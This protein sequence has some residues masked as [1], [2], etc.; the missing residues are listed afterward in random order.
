MRICVQPWNNETAMAENKMQEK[1]K[2]RI[3]EVWKSG[4]KSFFIKSS[5]FI[6]SIIIIIILNIIINKTKYG[7]YLDYSVLQL[8]FICLHSNRI[9]FVH[10]F[11]K[12][13]IF[14]LPNNPL[15]PNFRFFIR[16][17]LHHYNFFKYI[18]FYISSLKIFFKRD[19][20]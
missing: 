5:S 17:F 3:W 7:Y 4:W 6:F 10:R 13:Q 19:K 16:S 18:Y 2:N 11:G 15:S 20:K 9:I 8:C 14:R 12:I 1:K